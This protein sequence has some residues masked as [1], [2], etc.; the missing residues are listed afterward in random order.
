MKDAERISIP[1]ASTPSWKDGA[2][3]RRSIQRTGAGR[4][5]ITESKSSISESFSLLNSPKPTEFGF[6]QG[7]ACPFGIRIVVLW[8]LLRQG[9]GIPAINATNHP[10]LD[11]MGRL[12]FAVGAIQ[13]FGGKSRW[14][15]DLSS[16]HNPRVIHPHIGVLDPVGRAIIVASACK[17]SIPHQSRETTAPDDPSCRPRSAGHFR[18]GS[19]RS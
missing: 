6:F 19:R 2:K 9:S 5:G 18:P 8:Y 16:L 17:P 4:Q 10:P 1:T 7:P 11:L 13:R 12:P 3:C 14:D 15:H